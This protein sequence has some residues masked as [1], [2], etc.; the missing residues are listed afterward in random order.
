MTSSQQHRE[1]VPFRSRAVFFA[2]VLVA[3]M[4]VLTVHAR[5]DERVLDQVL[6][7]T[8]ALDRVALEDARPFVDEAILRA[9]DPR[10]PRGER[11]RALSV[12]A[13]ARVSRVDSAFE[14]LVDDGDDEVRRVAREIRV[15]RA[16]AR[17]R[18]ALLESMRIDPDSRVR[19]RAVDLLWR[20]RDVDALEFLAVHDADPVVRA[21]ARKRHVQSVSHTLRG[22][23]VLDDPPRIDAHDVLSR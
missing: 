14:K 2:A 15:L 12:L 5:G 16:D 23:G 22:S 7:G 6:Q 20:A 8:H 3:V 19:E 1:F 9:L 21:R 13:S 10:P 4:A 11:L 17:Q 18:P